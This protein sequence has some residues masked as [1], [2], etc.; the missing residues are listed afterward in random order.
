MPTKASAG[1]E[2]LQAQRAVRAAYLLILPPIHPE[3]LAERQKG[4]WDK[5]VK[6]WDTWITT[7]AGGLM[8]LQWIVA[9][10]DVRFQW[11]APMP[12]VYH[13]G[14][15]LLAGLGYALFMWAMASNAFLSQAVRIQEERGHVVETGGPY[16]YVRHPG[17]VGTILAQLAT[18]LLLGSPWALIP[19]GASAALFVVRT[20]LGDSTLMQELPGYKAYAQE[21]TSRLL[22]DVW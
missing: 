2:T 6:T 1:H 21:T 9:G 11:T 22:P 5:G 18:P 12:L 20:W 17:Y 19:S 3:L 14:G 16:R 10:L 13:I 15:L 7:L 8:F 4:F